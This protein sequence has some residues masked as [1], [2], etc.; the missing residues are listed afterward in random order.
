MAGAA[1]ELT[2]HAQDDHFIVS[3]SSTDG[4]NR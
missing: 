1:V 3:Q 4:L 2:V